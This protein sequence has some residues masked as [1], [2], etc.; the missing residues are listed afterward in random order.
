M[1]VSQRNWQPQHRIQLLSI[2]QSLLRVVGFR[3]VHQIAVLPP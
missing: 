1:I 3:V 2:P